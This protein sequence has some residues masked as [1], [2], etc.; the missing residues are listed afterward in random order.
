TTAGRSGSPSRNG[1]TVVAVDRSELPR[2]A[3]IEE[4]ARANCVPG[5][6]RLEPAE[7]REIEPEAAGI[8]ALHS[9]TTAIVDYASVAR[10]L[11]AD[12]VAAGGSVRLGFEVSSLEALGSQVKVGGNGEQLG[13]DR[14]FICAGLHADRLA[15]AVGDARGPVIVP[16]RGEYF[17]LAPA[18]ESLVRGLVYPVPDPQY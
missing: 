1:K 12:V 8:A 4:R 3:A 18:A 11:A 15:R 13:F 2:L 5:L 10:Q 9:P 16:F 7:L 14:L 6:R 17:R